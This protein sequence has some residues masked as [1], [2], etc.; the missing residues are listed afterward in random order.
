VDWATLL[1]VLILLGLV[2]VSAVLA[3]GEFAFFSASRR[4]L[5][6]AEDERSRRVAVMLGRPWE[7]L[8]SLTVGASICDVVAVLFALRIAWRAF[9]EGAARIVASVV[10]LVLVSAII[11]VFARLLPRIYA[12]H[13]PETAAGI[14]ARPVSVLLLPVYPLVKA[15]TALT[16]GLFPAGAEAREVLVKAG[17]LRAIAGGNDETEPGPSK[18]L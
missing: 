7:L 11:A 12:A 6:E 9:P 10:T 2:S 17:E 8:M 14:L 16:R 3:S 18:P 4:E 5:A 15:L 1:D 13:N